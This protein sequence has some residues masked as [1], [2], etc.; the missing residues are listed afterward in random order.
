MYV[1]DHVDS[2]I[3]RVCGNTLT[4]PGQG[5]CH[6]CWHGTDR[7]IL[8]KDEQMGVWVHQQCLDWFGVDD[9][10]QYER[11]YIDNLD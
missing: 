6:I 11:M 1:G 3:C 2:H 8:I 4:P 5:G 10:M 9:V 7:G